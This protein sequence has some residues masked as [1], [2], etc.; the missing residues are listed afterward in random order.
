MEAD[1]AVAGV[2]G[3]DGNLWSLS[4]GD[5]EF[6]TPS[7]PSKTSMDVETA[8]RE[9]VHAFRAAAEREITLG[10]GLD[11]WIISSS[12]SSDIDDQNNAEEREDIMT[13]KY[14][15]IAWG[16]KAVSMKIEKRFF[17]L[18]RH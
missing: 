7:S 10:D 3:E 6:Q 8:V 18:P 17:S 2:S 13:R 14:N 9:V 15:K 11:V 1:N 5:D 12:K 16:N 4:H